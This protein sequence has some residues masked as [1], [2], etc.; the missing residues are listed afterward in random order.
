MLAGSNGPADA[1]SLVLAKDAMPFAMAYGPICNAGI[2]PSRAYAGPPMPKPTTPGAVFASAAIAGCATRKA[3]DSTSPPRFP[4]STSADA[5][6]PLTETEIRG[7]RP[8]IEKG[9]AAAF[10]AEAGPALGVASVSL[11]FA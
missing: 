11:E 1:P 2:R 9:I 4:V 8:S 10:G 5:V 6:T 3:P 7:L